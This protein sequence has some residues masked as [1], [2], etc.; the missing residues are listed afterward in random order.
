MATRGTRTQAT[1]QLVLENLESRLNRSTLSTLVPVTPSAGSAPLTQE[2]STMTNRL[3]R[4]D[5]YTEGSSSGVSYGA[6]FNNAKFSQAQRFFDRFHQTFNNFIH[7]DPTPTPTPSPTPT[8]IPT[9]I[10]TPTPD[11]TP[12]PAPSQFSTDPVSITQTNM[13][14][15]M[16]LTIT[17]TAGND[18]ILVTQSGGTLIITANG[19]VNTVSGNFGELA[20]YGLGGDDTLDVAGSVQVQSLIYGGAGSNLLTAAGAAKSYIVSIGNTGTDVLTG[21]GVN[22]SFWADTGD[23]VNASAAEISLGGVHK[24]ASFYQPFTTNPASAN[25]ISTALNGQNLPDPTDAGTTVRLSNRTLFGT[26]PQMTDVNQGQ[27]GD[28]YF[29]ASIQAFAYKVPGRLENMAVDL[30]DGTYAVQFVRGGVT[31]YVRVDADFSSAPW[32]GEYYAH[33]TGNGPIWAMVMEKAYA[34]YRTGQNTYASL[35]SGWTGSAYSD[36]GVTNTTFSTWGNQLN[37]YNTLLNATA[38][39]AVTIITNSTI[40][41][42]ASLIGSHAY[43]VVNVYTDTNGVE[44][45][46]LR[47]PWGMD[48]IGNDG[49]TA[50][51]LVRIT[52]ANIQLDCSAGTISV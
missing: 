5:S 13:G 36:L 42:G 1:R 26:G 10:P 25:Y 43:T 23:V 8:P 39:H 22:T 21:N 29:L 12:T 19:H 37:L 9:P 40:S 28:C 27:V 2:V 34:F 30:G 52:L 41:G 15:L 3:Y 49:N 47:N 32:G 11:P 38:N 20:V 45:A 6:A 33:T 51:G 14:S 4:L 31:S 50:D 35:N 7:P 44:W 18:S 24:V 48:G 17:G 16:R 46:T